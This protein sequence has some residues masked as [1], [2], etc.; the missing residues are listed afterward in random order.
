MSDTSQLPFAGLPWGPPV[1]PDER[2][3]RA[4]RLV[5]RRIERYRRRAAA[6]VERFGADAR[7]PSSV[8][9]FGR[10]GEEEFGRGAAGTCTPSVQECED[11]LIPA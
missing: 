6:V 3:A 5:E 4:Q 1:A 7:L 2:D 9:V 10:D 11:D 8:T